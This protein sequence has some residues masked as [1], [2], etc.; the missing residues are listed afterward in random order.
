MAQ[1]A[2]GPQIAKEEARPADAAPPEVDQPEAAKGGEA[3]Q[4]AVQAKGLMDQ[5]KQMVEPEVFANFVQSHI[6]GAE[7]AEP[8]DAPRPVVGAVPSEGGVAG[9]PRV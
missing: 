9:V 4:L 8:T 6:L 3:E 5:L 7:A 2:P 1:M